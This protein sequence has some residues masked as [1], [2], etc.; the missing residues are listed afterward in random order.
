MKYTLEQ[1]R[2]LGGFTQVEIAQK[3]GMSEKT[4]IQYEKYR[5]VFRMD[6][7]HKF[8]TLVKVNISDIIFFENKLKKICS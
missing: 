5:K 2:I 4:Y 1:A 6:V 7:A 8:S 3:L